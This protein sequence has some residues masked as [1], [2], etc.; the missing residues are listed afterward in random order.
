M[1]RGHE[2]GMPHRS[3]N[4]CIEPQTKN[5]ISTGKG[6]DIRYSQVERTE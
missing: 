6:V 5:K 1:V 2:W 4:C 3:G